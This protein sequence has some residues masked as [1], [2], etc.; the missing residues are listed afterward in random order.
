M[1]LNN[2]K[3]YTPTRLKAVKLAP[4]KQAAVA[5]A[6]SSPPARAHPAVPSHLVL[7]CGGKGGWRA[8]P[9]CD[10]SKGL[11]RSSQQKQR[12][13]LL[14]W[15][16]VVLLRILNLLLDLCCLSSISVWKD[17]A[18]FISHLQE[19]AAS[20]SHPCTFWN[21]FCWP[22][23]LLAVLLEGRKKTHLNRHF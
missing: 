15:P 16:V 13:Q 11:L 22:V 19:G 12:T 5:L 23:C 2:R 9:A 3:S 17:L 4:A 8:F 14:S 6:P 10:L 21:S 7:G 18:K 1:V 20:H